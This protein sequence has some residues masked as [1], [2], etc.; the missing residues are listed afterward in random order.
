MNKMN[1]RH[2]LTLLVLFSLS[3]NGMEVMSPTATAPVF[4]HA[5]IIDHKDTT[6][7]M[8][9][10]QR[11]IPARTQFADYL[12]IIADE[13]I[14]RDRNIV[15]VKYN[16]TKDGI[17]IVQDTI[18]AEL[19]KTETQRYVRRLDDNK[20]YVRIAFWSTWAAYQR[21]FCYRQ[22]APF[23]QRKIRD[24]NG[25]ELPRTRTPQGI[26]CGAYLL[27]TNTIFN[28]ET[29][30]LTG[31]VTKD[32][33]EIAQY[34]QEIPCDQMFEQRLDQDATLQIFPFL[35][36]PVP[37]YSLYDYVDIRPANQTIEKDR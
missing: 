20:T 33:Q 28:A 19:G 31:T 7:P 12:L 21:S 32:S 29:M 6:L 2:I 35:N 3:L 36:T 25:I 17:E 15:T 14:D 4:Y 10:L 16:V 13:T 18:E 22:N 8:R 23:A 1:N 37:E 27:K 9:V 11:S 24:N 26:Q 30:R 5:D 34:D